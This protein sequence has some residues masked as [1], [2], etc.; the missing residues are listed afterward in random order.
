MHVYRICVLAII[1]IKTKVNT[2][3]HQGRGG[4]PHIYSG[5]VL[6]SLANVKLIFLYMLMLM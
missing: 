1:I 2:I 4:G 3:V 6:C 5:K